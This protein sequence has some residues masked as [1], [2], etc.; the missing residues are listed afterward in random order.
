MPCDDL[1]GQDGVGGGG[2]EGSRE[3]IYVNIHISESHCWTAETHCKA[4]IC[5]LKINKIK[6]S[7]K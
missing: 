4:I 3:R 7:I 5:Q 1:E 2:Q 6:K